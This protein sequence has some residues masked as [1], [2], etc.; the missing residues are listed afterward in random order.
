MWR[1]FDLKLRVEVAL[2]AI[3]PDLFKDEKRRDLLR[4]EVRAARAVH[5]QP[6]L[7]M[8]MRQWRKERPNLRRIA[9][10]LNWLKSLNNSELNV[11]KKPCI[12]MR[13]FLFLVL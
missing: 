5:R 2:K 6:M 4:R 13:G 3:L 1:A 9:E 11:S 7:Q 10:S 8:Q 12:L